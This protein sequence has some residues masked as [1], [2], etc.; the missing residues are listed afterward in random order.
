MEKGRL[1]E[2]RAKKKKGNGIDV[3]LER[4]IERQATVG[5]LSNALFLKNLYFP[6]IQP[7]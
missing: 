4:Q 2:S 7:T 3:S 1:N 6:T 5:S